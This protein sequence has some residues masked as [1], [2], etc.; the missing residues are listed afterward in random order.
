MSQQQLCFFLCNQ[1]GGWFQWLHGLRRGVSGH[2]HAG[3][4]DLNV[5]GGMDVSLVSVVCCQVE[6]SAMGQS[7]VQRNPTERDV[8]DWDHRTFN[9]EDT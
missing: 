9:S 7:L 2:S 3:I 1:N 5:A 6:V 8:S 4:V